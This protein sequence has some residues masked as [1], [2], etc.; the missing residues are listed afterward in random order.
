MTK[1]KL[2]LGGGLEP[3]SEVDKVPSVPR[4]RFVYMDFAGTVLRVTTLV[5]WW[6][7]IVPNRIGYAV[8]DDAIVPDTGR[9][10]LRMICAC[11]A[12]SDEEATALAN[13]CRKKF[14]DKGMWHEG[15][16]IEVT[17]ASPEQGSVV[18]CAAWTAFN[19]E[20]IWPNSRVSPFTPGKIECYDGEEL[21]I[22]CT[23]NTVFRIPVTEDRFISC[24]ACFREFRIYHMVETREVDADKADVPE[25]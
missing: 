10:C 24:P 2:S 8:I 6:F 5:P 3:K 23:C 4:M 22:C 12:G 7:F 9:T 21:R 19:S 17:E 13:K 14:I 18:V 16:I 25:N 20:K 15:S 11:L 1:H